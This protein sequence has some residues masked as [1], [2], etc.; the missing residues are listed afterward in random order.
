MA[1]ATGEG[2]KRADLRGKEMVKP[3]TALEHLRSDGGE[4]LEGGS[5]ID[6]YHTQLWLRRG[7]SNRT[8]RNVGISWSAHNEDNDCVTEQLN[9]RH[10]TRK[11]LMWPV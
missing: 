5:M 11:V 8:S 4:K 9:E 2:F 10:L 1:T 7:P 3:Y 6:A